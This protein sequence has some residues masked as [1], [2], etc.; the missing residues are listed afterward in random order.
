M[1]PVIEGK[2]IDIGD[3]LRTHVTD[4][5]DDLTQKYFNNTH[6]ATVTFSKEGHG[7]GTFKVHIS[8]QVGKNI[9]INAE[10]EAGD[11]YGAF[12]AAAEKAAKRLRRNKKKLRDH[13]E[14]AEKTPESEIIKARGYILAGHDENEEAPEQD[15][16]SDGG[17]SMEQG[18]DPVIVA[19]MTTHIETMSVSDAV[20]RMDL[21]GQSALLF[22]NASHDGLNMVYKRTDGTIGWVDPEISDQEKVA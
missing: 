3:A 7:H 22:R 17:D 20:M 8:I 16:G 21:S 14:R 15:N 6:A 10:A 19:E 11:P 12:D 18:D 13:H 5:I 1:Q 9:M 2:H 4:K